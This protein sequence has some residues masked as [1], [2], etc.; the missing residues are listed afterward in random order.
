MITIIGEQEKF[1][2]MYYIIYIILHTYITYIY[3][4]SIYI[5]N[6]HTHICIYHMITIIEKED[7]EYEI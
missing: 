1:N 6:T 2:S 5:S 3:K 7:R 4:Q